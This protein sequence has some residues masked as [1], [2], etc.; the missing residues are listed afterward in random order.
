MLVAEA[1][2]QLQQQRLSTEKKLATHLKATSSTVTY[3]VEE[4][5]A[6]K[7]E[8]ERLNT[9]IS[10]LNDPESI[11]KA[12]EK[13]NAQYRQLEVQQKKEEN[14]HKATLKAVSEEIRNAVELMI[15]RLDSQLKQKLLALMS[16]KN[17]L[18]LETEKFSKFCL[19]RIIDEG[20]SLF[21]NA[22]FQATAV[23]TNVEGLQV[24]I[25]GVDLNVVRCSI[26]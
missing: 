18:T 8:L 16:Q 14:E 12:I 24:C 10:S 2:K 23:S 17:S 19:E 26:G 9:K 22:F 6:K 21:F 7:K 25:L 11:E 5:Q 13:Y 15:A 3:Q 1:N 4:S 20:P